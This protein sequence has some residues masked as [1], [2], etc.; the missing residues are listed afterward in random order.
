MRLYP[1]G[2]GGQRRSPDEVKRDGWHEQGVLAVSVNDQPVDI[3][4]S[5]LAEDDNTPATALTFAVSNAQAGSV[6][7]LAD[8]RTARFTP[9]PGASGMAGFSFTATDAGALLSN[10]GTVTVGGSPIAYT[11]NALTSGNWSTAGNWNSNTPAVSYRGADVRFLTGQTLA[12]ST[13]LTTQNTIPGTMHMKTRP[14]NTTDACH[15]S[16]RRQRVARDVD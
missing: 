16:I 11:W 8:G 6:T 3:D 5:T 4:L 14:Y 13:T 15:E 12:A 1:K 9:T 2:Y 7:L 10:V